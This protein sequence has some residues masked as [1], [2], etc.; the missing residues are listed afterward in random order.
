MNSG[1]YS[2][3][4]GSL[5][6]TELID[7]ISNNLANA[8]TYGFK[9]E[10]IGFAALLDGATQAQ[11]AGGTNFA[12]VSGSLTDHDAGPTIET[13]GD[14]D[15]AI[16]GE[17]FFRVRNDE[18]LFYTRVGN[19]TRAADGALITRSGDTVM[20]A[21]NEA[22]ILPDGSI[23]IDERGRVLGENGQVGEIPIFTMDQR[24]LI[25]NGGGRFELQD[26]DVPVTITTESQVMQ[27]HLEQSNVKMMEETALMMSNLRSFEAYEKAM[28]NYHEV[29][30]KALEIA[31]F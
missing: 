23:T 21:D 19:F 10:R 5:A 30:A 24:A 28:K 11:K 18:G 4:S 8:G 15:L 1:I 14:L 17:G 20:S 26:E 9:K 7:V 6:R 31:A 16:V 13:G 12:V 3:L 22:I 29:N 25:K 27:G 2:A